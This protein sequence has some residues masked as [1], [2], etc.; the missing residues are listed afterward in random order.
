VPL[1]ILHVVQTPTGGGPAQA[2]QLAQTSAEHGAQVRIAF[3]AEPP[4]TPERPSWDAFILPRGRYRRAMHIWRAARLADIVHV[5][6]TRAALWALPALVG[7]RSVFTP[8]GLHLLRRPSGHF[9][10]RVARALVRVIARASDAIVCVSP[11]EASELATLGIPPSKL[12]LIP[13]G[14][15]AGPPPD[16]LLRQQGRTQLGLCD[17]DLAVLVLARLEF[18]KDPSRAVAV[19]RGLEQDRVVVLL[20][21][22]GNLM[23]TVRAAAPRNVRI[24]G[25]RGDTEALLAAC[26][27]VMN[28]SRWEGM[29]LVLVE[30]MAANRPIVA[31]DVVG[32]RELIGDAGILVK[33]D[34]DDAYRS[35]LRQLASPDRRAD[36]ARRGRARLADLPSQ[37]EMWAATESIYRRIA[38]GRLL[39][40]PKGGREIA[41]S[42]YRIHD[43]MPGLVRRG[44]FVRTLTPSITSGNRLMSAGRDLLLALRRWDVL[45]VQRPGRR[46]EER[47]FLR[48]AQ[49]RGARIVVDVDDPVDETGVFA[50]ALRNADAMLAGSTAVSERYRAAGLAIHL[51]PTGVDYARY[52]TAA[53]RDGSAR[54]EAEF[55][56][57]WVGDGPAYAGPLVRMVKGLPEGHDDVVRIIGTRGDARLEAALKKAARRMRLELHAHV[58][59]ES[60]AAVA[61]EIARFS[62]GLVPFREAL[63]ASFKTIQYLAAGVPPVVES[64]GEGER[65]A[66][67]ALG[68]DAP[69]VPAGDSCALASALERLR[70]GDH[71]EALARRG[72]AYVRRQC[73][74]DVLVEALDRVLRGLV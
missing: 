68:D 15:R 6:G 61:E 23:A 20:A 16:E 36:L 7:R 35:A 64:G 57:G 10:R 74:H 51:V 18:Q 25:H 66:R 12:H 56:V 13:N 14:V 26:D 9:Y 73:S 34:D 65:H 11:S 49:R 3:P 4:P 59:W 55:V 41:S 48:L 69:I 19:A 29:P 45:L 42:R 39:V 44:W 2:K 53:A 54:A 67:A 30:A 27:V 71:R 28:T 8:H 22:D 1:R 17:G 52:A 5:H 31:S 43:L 62:V 24:L 32:N 63:G 40:A 58:E 38:Q 21:G 46:R 50:W 47:L 72:Q 33:Q 37:D 70:R 60:E